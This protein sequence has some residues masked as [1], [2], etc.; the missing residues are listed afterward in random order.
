MIGPSLVALLTLSSLPPA[1]LPP[2]PITGDSLRFESWH[3]AP[4]APCRRW[5]A[6]RRN[7]AANAGGIGAPRSFLSAQVAGTPRR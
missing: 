7:P 3:A 6:T 2:R 5:W 4:L 1:T